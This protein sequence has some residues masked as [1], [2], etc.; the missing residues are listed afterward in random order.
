MHIHFV[1]SALTLTLTLTLYARSKCFFLCISLILCISNQARIYPS[2]FTHRTTLPQNIH[3]KLGQNLSLS[4]SKCMLTFWAKSHSLS[5]SLSLSHTHAHTHTNSHFAQGTFIS[6]FF[7]RTL[8]SFTGGEFSTSMAASDLSQSSSIF[9][10]FLLPSCLNE[11]F[12][13]VS[14]KRVGGYLCNQRES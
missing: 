11:A 12:E 7:K 2:R 6:C 5:L 4:F 9:L 3:I 14:V 13:T 10:A 1:C 8:P